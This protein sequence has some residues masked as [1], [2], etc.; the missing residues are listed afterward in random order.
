MTELQ[1]SLIA[2]FE[3]HQADLPW[4]RDRDPYYVWLSEIMLQQTQ[5]TTV[6]PYFERFLA[7]FPTVQVLAAAPLDDV[8]KQWEGLGYYSRAHNLHRAAQVVVN[9]YNGVFPNT[10][11][12][13][14]KLPGIGRYTAGAIASLAFG[15]DAPILDGNVIRVL[16]RLFNITDDVSAAST[17]TQ[18]WDL[19]EKLVPSGHAASWNEGLMELGRTICTP[20]SPDCPR[21]PIE[22]SCEARQLGVQTERPIKAPRAKV[23]H[24]DVTAA[25]IHRDDGRILIAQ[26]PLEGML[27]GLWE[28]P[29][30][31][32]DPGET[33]TEC[34]KR[35][36]LEELNL[37]IAVGEQIGVVRHSYTHMSITL[38]AFHC[39]YLGGEPQKIGVA[40]YAWIMPDELDRYA[41]PVTDQKII[42]ILR[43]GGG[44]LGMDF[45]A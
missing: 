14:Q 40:D 8:L 35:E 27:G 39:E 43:N 19:S 22:T 17:R 45:L 6:I 21:C 5:V 32:R 15:V 7:R 13:L 28:F 36:I 24:F 11:D 44:Q 18:L 29:G 12:E 31:K 25:V 20:K 1:Q 26:R 41:F 38:Y 33:L 34:L 30:G 4:R 2:W 37:E 23:P 3:A 16:A 42:T 9:E 10:V